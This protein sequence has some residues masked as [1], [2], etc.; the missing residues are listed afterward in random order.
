MQ[1]SSP[2]HSAPTGASLVDPFDRQPTGRKRPRFFYGWTIVLS[3]VATNTLLSAAYFQGFGA[4]IL[5]MESHFGWNRTIISIALSLRN[6][7]TGL[8]SPLVGFLLVKMTPRRVIFYSGVITGIGLIGLGL[9]NGLVMFFFFFVVASFGA[10]GASHAVTWPVLIARW[11]RRKR[12]IAMGF[13]VMGPIFGS[14]FLILNTSIEQSIGDNGWRYVFIGYGILVIVGVSLISLFVRNDP[15]EHGLHPD[16]D[17]PVG[18]EQEAQARSNARSDA[19]FTLRQVLHTREFWLLVSYM[20]GLFIVNSA[21]HG[22]QIPYMVNDL[23]FSKTEAAISVTLVFTLSAFGRIGGGF[24][25]DH[26]DYRIVLFVMAGVMGLSVLYLQIVQPTSVLTAM[27]FNA[28]FGI[29]FGSMI[30]IR[31]TL[32]GMMFGLRSL[33]PV[34]GLLQ[35]GAVAAGMI[36]PLFLGIMFDINGSY[37]EAMW[38]LIVVAF[39][40]APLVFFM[41]SPKTLRQRKIEAGELLPEIS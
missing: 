14:P 21:I 10:S 8:V 37:R 18:E 15:A 29:G 20:G 9:I 38:G 4:L 39:V 24:L 2:P 33:G 3:S 26:G 6:V 41:S 34:I 22:H 1:T 11:F 13:A 35:G 23:G 27:P 28:M 16:G 19:G 17:T 40:M 31:G 32:G 12:G 30:P 36:G 25:M 5:P 7:E